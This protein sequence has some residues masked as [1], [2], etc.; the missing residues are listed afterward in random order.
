MVR[1]YGADAARLTLQYTEI[2]RSSWS[3]GPGVLS[4]E[5]VQMVQCIHRQDPYPCAAY[6]KNERDGRFACGMV[7]EES[8]WFVIA[9]VPGLES[10]ASVAGRPTSS[11]RHTRPVVRTS[12]GNQLICYKSSISSPARPLACLT[13]CI[14]DISRRRADAFGI[15]QIRSHDF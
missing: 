13:R 15:H 8:H 7:L 2:L 5:V 3:P 6:S 14:A 1:A 4:M 9:C 10:C 12:G 11:T